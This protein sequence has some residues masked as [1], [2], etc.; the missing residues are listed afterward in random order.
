MEKPELLK[1]VLAD[2][3]A[4]NEERKFEEA[5]VGKFCEYAANWFKEKGVIGV[6]HTSDGLALR[7][8]DGSEYVLFS[9][10]ADITNSASFSVT[11]TN[12]KIEKPVND[13]TRSFNITGR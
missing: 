5:I 13:F 8:A 4:H 1:K 10:D 3:C 6:G 11:G 9:S 2:Y 7:L 12:S